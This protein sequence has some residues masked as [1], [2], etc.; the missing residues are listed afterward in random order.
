MC[1]AAVESSGHRGA[2][3]KHRQPRG[4]NADSLPPSLLD[5]TGTGSR[6]KTRRF[7]LKSLLS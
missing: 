6:L 3:V 2:D 1:G 4:D 5:Y 7:G